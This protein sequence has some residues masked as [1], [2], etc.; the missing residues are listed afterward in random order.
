[1]RKT[2][3][4]GM[5]QVET[6]MAI[7]VG[8][9]TILLLLIAHFMINP[10]LLALSTGG[11]VYNLTMAYL[12]HRKKFI[13]FASWALRIGNLLFIASAVFLTGGLAS[14]FLGFFALYLLIIGIRHGFKGGALACT[15]SLILLG[16][17]NAL[18]GPWDEKWLVRFIICAGTLIMITVAAGT[19][20]QLRIQ[21]EKELAESRDKLQAVLNSAGEGIVVTD[22]E[23]RIILANP[24]AARLWETPVRELIGKNALTLIRKWAQPE[25]GPPLELSNLLSGPSPG[26]WWIIETPTPSKRAI[27]YIVSPVRNTKGVPFGLV[28]VMR[29]VTDARELERLKQDFLDMLV[30]DLR[31]PLGVILTGVEFLLDDIKAGR[32]I[33]DTEVLNLIKESTS[34]M[35]NLIETL[36]D[37]RLLEEKRF[38]LQQ[39]L[40]SLN[41]FIEGAEKLMELKLRK[42]EITLVKEIPSDLPPLY[43]DRGVISRVF[44]NLLDNAIKFSPR[45]GE[46]RL[47]AQQVG[48]MVQICISDQGPG[49]DP[50]VIPHIFERYGGRRQKRKGSHG[51]GLPFC[52]L[53]VEAHGGRIWVESQE[54]TGATF[55][56][57]LPLAKESTAPL[58]A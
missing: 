50:D 23:G 12:I 46:I 35:D 40:V 52:K 42:K 15:L 18:A 33:T 30:H 14:P 4:L 43:V 24:I 7:I 32:A 58:N 55:C 5:P 13:T 36:L 34:T 39:E 17:I 10:W 21:H 27:E 28:I 26:A 37:F 8:I 44:Q 19:M 9:G 1:M 57:T 48:E 16:T 25:M 20:G 11:V 54:T 3:P 6:L 49:I 56:F 31:S 2:P 22:K 45:G 29:D 41:E 47:K 53:A 51:L 38:P